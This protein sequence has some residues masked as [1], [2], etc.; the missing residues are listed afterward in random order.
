MDPTVAMN[1]IIGLLSAANY[2]EQRQ[3]CLDTWI[4]MLPARIRCYFLIGNPDLRAPRLS[5]DSG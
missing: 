2:T 3:A 1:I 5:T 4:P